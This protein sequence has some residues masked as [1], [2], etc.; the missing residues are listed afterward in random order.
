MYNRSLAAFKA[1]FAKKIA[2]E[3]GKMSDPEESFMTSV[4]SR[5]FLNYVKVEKD[6]LYDD[7]PDEA[8]MRYVEYLM[9]ERPI[10]YVS[11]VDEWFPIWAMKWRQ[12]V[13]LADDKDFDEKLMQK[14]EQGTRP[15]F[16][17][18]LFEEAKRFALGS[19]VKS[20]EVCFTDTLSETIVKNIL[21]MMVSRSN[22]ADEVI[23][24]LERNPILL[25]NEVTRRVK[26][27]ARFKG[28]LIAVRFEN[29]IFNNEAWW[30]R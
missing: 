11:L 28:P 24:A 22:G 4:C 7:S 27:L 20:G 29:V 13:K 3:F 17:L 2:Q 25:L 14:I 10:V 8:A 18:P 16:N 30:A 1:T 5:D 19:L 9:E 12:R 23:K 21:F 26:A 15:F 6:F